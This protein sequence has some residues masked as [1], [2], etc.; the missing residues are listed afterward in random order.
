MVFR[1]ETI[2]GVEQCRLF[3]QAT[4]FP[5]PGFQIKGSAIFPSIKTPG[6][7]EPKTETSFN[8]LYEGHLS[9]LQ[10]HLWIDACIR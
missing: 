10:V 2:R 8:L 4:F 1:G 3:S 9:A 7:E 6:T 5:V